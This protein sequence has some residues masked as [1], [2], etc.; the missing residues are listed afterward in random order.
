MPVSNEKERDIWGAQ[1]HV[2]PLPGGGGGLTGSAGAY[3]WVYA[4]A[5]NEVEYREMV[6]AEM[7]KLGLFIAEVE[8]IGMFEPHPE[9]VDETRR[10]FERLSEEWPVQYHSFHCYPADEA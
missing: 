4:L 5:K 8:S 9:D 6:A 1:L 7:A 10:C 3:A 2:R